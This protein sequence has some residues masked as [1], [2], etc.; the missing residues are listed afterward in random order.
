LVPELALHDALY[1]VVRRAT[2]RDPARR[3]ASAADM[4]DQLRAVLREIVAAE[5]GRAQPATSAHFT[6]KVR[7][8]LDQPDRHALPV[9][10]FS[11]EAP[12]AA[13]LTTVIA[14]DPT[15]LVD[16]LRAAPEQTVEVELQLVRALLDADRAD[17]AGEVLRALESTHAHDWRTH[18]YAALH[19]LAV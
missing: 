17:E 6:G 16:S 12:A 1:Q 4:A 18:W 14:Q 15:T 8:R 3:F 5:T 11:L 13:Y 2:E 19:H 9:P 10:L 7:G